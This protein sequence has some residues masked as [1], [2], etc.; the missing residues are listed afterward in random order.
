MLKIHA[1]LDLRKR[2]PHFRSSNLL[3]QLLLCL[4]IAF[5]TEKEKQERT[6]LGESL[7]VEEEVEARPGA[8]HVASVLSRNQQRN[9]HPHNLVVCK[10]G[11]VLQH[12]SMM[13]KQE[14]EGRTQSV[15]R[16]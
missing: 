5:R 1:L 3:S 7:A 15:R 14:K 16:S 13:S 8:R 9:H 2:G 4:R 10:L 6:H 12:L 11:P